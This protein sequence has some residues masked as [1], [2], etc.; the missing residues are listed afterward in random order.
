MFWK[1][2]TKAGAITSIAS[3][4]LVTLIWEELVKKHLPDSLQR[5]DAV[6]PAITISVVALIVVSLLT[7]KRPAAEKD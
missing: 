5:L 6:L 3:G 7:Q 4:T 2:A 1:G